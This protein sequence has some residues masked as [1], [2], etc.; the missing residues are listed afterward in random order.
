LRSWSSIETTSGGD[1][2]PS[3][4]CPRWS[5]RTP[6]T[7]NETLGRRLAMV[8][9]ARCSRAHDPQ[10]ALRPLLDAGCFGSYAQRVSHKAAEC[11]PF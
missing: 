5:R 1:P 8:R 6:S 3:L 7:P 4:S 9:L 11:R 10:R 2:I